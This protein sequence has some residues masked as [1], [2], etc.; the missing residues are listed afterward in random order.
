MILHQLL[1]NEANNDRLLIES[2]QAGM[3]TALPGIV[4]SFDNLKQTCV[5]QPAIQGVWYKPDGT[6][7]NTANNVD[8]PLLLDC[9]VC[10]SSGGGY[11]L[12][13]PLQ[14]GDEVLV[15]FSSRCIDNAWYLGNADKDGNIITRPQAEY[16]MHDLS[17]GFVIPGYKSIPR[18]I[19][20]ISTTDVQLRS[21]DGLA[22]IGINLST[23]NITINTT[24]N[25]NLTAPLTNI[26]GDINLTGTMT[27]SVDVIA[28]GKSLKMHTHSD[29]QG[30]NTG[31][32]N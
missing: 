27:A 28:A 15:V 8:L 3:W 32:P 1:G 16:R 31:A 5:V 25:V 4:V 17:D 29:P 26:V 19:P 22:L 6:G 30:S 9:P 14:K 2:K 7:S 23:H 21:D 20:N 12:T 18:N 11:S 13:F 24:G 10:F